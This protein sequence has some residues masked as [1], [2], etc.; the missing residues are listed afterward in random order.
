MA[1]SELTNSVCWRTGLEVWYR[2]G[3]PT[4]DPHVHLRSEM[5]GD[6]LGLTLMRSSC[7]KRV[8]KEMPSRSHGIGCCWLK[9]QRVCLQAVASAPCICRGCSRTGYWILVVHVP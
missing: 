5:K 1:F 2:T 7:H 3:T 4:G 8:E 9:R 6:H